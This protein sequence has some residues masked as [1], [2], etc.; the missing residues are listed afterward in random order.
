MNH[1]TDAASRAYGGRPRDGRGRPRGGDLREG[2]FCGHGRPALWQQREARFNPNRQVFHG[3]LSSLPRHFGP[4]DRL[5]AHPVVSLRRSGAPTTQLPLRLEIGAG[6]CQ[7]RTVQSGIELEFMS[8]EFVCFVVEWSLG[9]DSVEERAE[10]E[11]LGLVWRFRT[12]A[13]GVKRR[14]H[15]ARGICLKGPRVGAWCGGARAERA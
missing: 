14:K 12:F 4:H 11:I 13:T 9:G 5:V 6:S 10:G 8:L 7:W 15:R 1:L 3:F 2:G